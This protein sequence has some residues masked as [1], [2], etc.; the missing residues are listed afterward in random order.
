[1]T[2][3]VVDDKIFQ[4]DDKGFDDKKLSMNFTEV[5]ND[6]KICHCLKSIIGVHQCWNTQKSAII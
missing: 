6:V 5:R 2:K 3:S 1:M 4:W